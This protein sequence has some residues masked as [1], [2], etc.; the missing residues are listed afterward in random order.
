M[1]SELSPRPRVCV[2]CHRISS[3]TITI[4]SPDPGSSGHKRKRPDLSPCPSASISC[5]S[6]GNSSEDAAG[7]PLPPRLKAQR[8][9]REEE[10]GSAAL[11]VSAGV[12]PLDLSPCSEDSHDACLEAHAGGSDGKRGGK[13]YSGK[14][15]PTQG[16]AKSALIRAAR[17]TSALM[18]PLHE[19]CAPPAAQTSRL[20][21]E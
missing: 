16:S 10:V 14:V 11:L 6:S 18:Q 7:G 4:V 3:G 2:T 17:A 21:F 1:P 13:L 8:R 15:A 5:S 9:G 19:A 20:S 12:H